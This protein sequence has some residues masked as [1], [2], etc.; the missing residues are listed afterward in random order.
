MTRRK[1]KGRGHQ[2]HGS[3]VREA[4]ERWVAE[5]LIV[6]SIVVV[7]GMRVAVS[8]S[9][10]RG[11]YTAELVFEGGDRAVVDA[12]SAEELEGLIAAVV[13]PAALARRA[14]GEPARAAGAGPVADRP[15]HL[16]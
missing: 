14:A 9:R 12:G 7:S 1:G 2:G 5:T 13:Y 16:V 10:R 6:D 4:T 11:G 3:T 8:R 15:R